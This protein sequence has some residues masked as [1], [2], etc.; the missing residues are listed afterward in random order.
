MRRTLFIALALFIVSGLFYSSH[1]AHALTLSPV[2]FEIMGDPGENIVENVTITNDGDSDQTYYLSF[3][4]FEAKGETGTP[5]FVDPK[6]GVGTWLSGVP[7]ID[8]KAGES[9]MVPITIKIPATAEPGGY[10]GAIFWG[11][12]PTSIE[13]GSSVSIGAQ[14]G[15][16]M[17]LSVRGEV[18]EAG[19]VLDF[20]TKDEKNSY[21]ALPVGF[22]YRFRNDGGDRI[23]PSGDIV[24]K[25]TFGGIAANVPANKVEG[26][27]LPNSVRRFETEWQSENG[28]NKEMPTDLSFIGYVRYEWNNFAFGRYHA[29]IH[30]TFGADSS[31]NKSSESISFWVFPWHLLITILIVFLL[32][33][34]GGRFLLKRYNTWIIEKAREQIES[35]HGDAP[36]STTT[37]KK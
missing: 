14:T 29:Q 8:L 37:T 27:I 23:K 9:K 21:L 33:I 26:N 25:N 4:N 16:L 22:T 13:G 15:I 24:I 18:K 2:R 31:N 30:L 12:N 19:G 1:D 3:A 20:K 11:T 10:F 7:S 35:S 34:F 36:R 6:E 17:L 28:S 32:F 5:S